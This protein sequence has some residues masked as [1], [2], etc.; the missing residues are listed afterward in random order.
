VATTL[1]KTGGAPRVVTITSRSMTQESK[2]VSQLY[3]DLD[4][5]HPD[6]ALTS[7]EVVIFPNQR[8]VDIACRGIFPMRT[9]AAAGWSGLLS[10]RMWRK[11]VPVV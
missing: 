10:P 7:A 11:V 1:N 5:M 3:K 4:C 2:L 9:V 6:L 8:L